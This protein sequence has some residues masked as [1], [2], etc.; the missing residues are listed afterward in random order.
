MRKNYN[1]GITEKRLNN[2][3]FKRTEEA[4]LRTFFEED[5]FIGA[6]DMAKKAGVAR[7]TFYHHHRT[8]REIVPDY[9]RYILRKYN[10]LVKRVD[11]KKDLRIVFERMMIFI[12]QNKRVFEIF[13][14]TGDNSVLRS[15]LISLRLKI[16]NYA[17]LP[18]NNDKII[19]VYFDE[20]IGLITRWIE[21]G[22]DN[23]G[24]MMLIV[25]VLY[26]TNTLRPR[27]KGLVEN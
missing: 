19:E 6:K 27:L 22:C 17:R 18:K 24:R 13:L 8:V 2:R 9:K 11:E 16:I 15:M 10:R 25:D 5:I 26:L 1:P 4:I 12:I 20:I 23:D 7:S 3:R 21:N 14:K